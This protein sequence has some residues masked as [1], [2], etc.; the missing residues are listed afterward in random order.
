MKPF[1]IFITLIVLLIVFTILN[2]LAAQSQSFNELWCLE[3]I[4]E[5]TGITIGENGVIRIT[6]DGGLTWETKS[7]KSVNTLKKTSLLVNDELVIVGMNGTIVK[8]T[9]LGETWSLKLSPVNSN[10]LGVSFGGRDSEVGIAVGT[11]ALILRSTDKGETWS[12]LENDGLPK[13]YNYNAVS[14]A[15][16]S[17]GIIVGDRGL[18]LVTNDGG[19]SWSNV[20]NSLPPVSYKF[21][22]MLTEDLAYATGEYGTIIKTTD[23]GET[24]VRLNTNVL[25]TLYRIRFAD[26][27]IAISV[28]TDGTVLKTTNGGNSF[29]IIN[30]GV[31]NN[32]NC[33]F[34]INENISLSGGADGIIIR[35]T[36]GGLTWNSVENS[37][38]GPFAKKDILVS[39]FPNPFNPMTVIKYNLNEGANVK[40]EIFDI[41]GKLINTLAESYQN[42][43]S[44]SVVFNGDK[45]ASGI[46]FCRVTVNGI[47][48][49]STG[50]VKMIIT[51]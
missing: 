21:V 19:I 29:D 33:L 11:D 28:G 38:K 44:Y 32:L 46:Y 9:D 25:S 42:K 26:D 31:V 41:T 51:K 40:I 16:E 17:K 5:Q 1:R 15:T 45:Y 23:G 7:S 8:S 18:I 2:R 12:A 14:F 13:N 24:W 39:L 34:V 48:G 3:F 30:S 4:D 43:G 37:P 35:T 10:L 20:I 6:Y 27:L 36:D 22:I 49:I 47:S 50:T